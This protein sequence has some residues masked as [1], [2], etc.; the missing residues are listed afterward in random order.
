MA[1]WQLTIIGVCGAALFGLMWARANQQKAKGMSG[2]P[3][4]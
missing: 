4:I 2:P 3:R 1:I